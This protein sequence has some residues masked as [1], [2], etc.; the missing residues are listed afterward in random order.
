[1][2]AQPEAGLDYRQE[3]YAGEAED[4]ASILGL[5]QAVEVPLGHYTGVL[6]TRDVNPLEDPPAVE[7]KFFARGVGPLLSIG[8]AGGSDREELIS[9]RPG[10]ASE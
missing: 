9:F 2:P 1:M 7:L 3:Y 4:K 5:D 8:I 10:A 6:M